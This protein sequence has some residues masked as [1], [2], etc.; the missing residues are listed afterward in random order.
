MKTY[1]FFGMMTLLIVTA[2]SAQA[3]RLTYKGVCR[4]DVYLHHTDEHGRYQHDAGQY[5]V[6]NDHDRRRENAGGKAG[7]HHVG[8]LRSQGW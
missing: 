8:L 1:A 7:W 6:V 4:D 3:Y 2:L 5:V